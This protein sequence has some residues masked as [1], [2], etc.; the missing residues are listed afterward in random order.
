MDSDEKARYLIHNFW[1]SAPLRG[2]KFGEI[3]R[4]IAIMEEPEVAEKI[5]RHLGFWCL[6][7]DGRSPPE[8]P[9]GP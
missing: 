6:G 3:M 8:K 9:F 2:P 1:P 4:V 5:L 7:L